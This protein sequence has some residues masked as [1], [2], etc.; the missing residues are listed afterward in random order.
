MGPLLHPS[1]A[2]SDFLFVTCNSHLIF[3]EV[4]IPFGACHAKRRPTGEAPNGEAEVTGLAASIL[5]LLPES[6]KK[7]GIMWEVSQHISSIY[8]LDSP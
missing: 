7:N 3:F 5:F 1:S 6:K 8:E 2:T 4:F